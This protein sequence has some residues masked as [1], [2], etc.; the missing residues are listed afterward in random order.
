M[1]RPIKPKAVAS[2]PGGVAS[3][4]PFSVP[5]ESAFGFADSSGKF[6]VTVKVD[7]Y[8]AATV[9]EAVH[10]I[11]QRLNMQSDVIEAAQALIDYLDEEGFIDDPR[12]TMA[13]LSV[14]TPKL[15]AALYG[16]EEE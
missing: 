11:R 10:L 3:K 16:R 12:L 15:R 8:G 7:G 6:S 1:P 9:A 5:Y 13:G 14:Y 2:Q 4:L